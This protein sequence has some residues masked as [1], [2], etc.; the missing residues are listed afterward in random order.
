LSKGGCY[1]KGI[2][3][4]AP[5][6][7]ATDGAAGT[8][9]WPEFLVKVR[10]IERGRLFRHNVAGDLPGVDGSIDKRMLSG[11]VAAARG[12]R[13]FTYTHKPVFGARYAGN[14]DAI[15]KANENGFTIN[16]SG[17]N[18]AHADRLADLAIAPVVTVVPSDSPDKLLTPAG[19]VVQV[20]PEQTGKVPNCAAC[21]ACAAAN[22]RAI[23]GFRAHGIATRAADAVA[24]GE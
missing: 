19:R 6:D 2:R 11:L 3:A 1:A 21:G 17:N 24:R 10:R 16:L 9:A 15:R 18:L 8:L 23:I 13:G 7:R 14:R 4:R 22:R 20:C 12:K 5:W